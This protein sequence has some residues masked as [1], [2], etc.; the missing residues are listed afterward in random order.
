M[1][2]YVC[3]HV[4]VLYAVLYLFF[5]LFKHQWLNDWFEIRFWWVCP[6][7][8]VQLSLHSGHTIDC[9]Q[10]FVKDAQHP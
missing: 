2:V 5:G 1:C 7:S 3:V 8:G 4:C 9:L 10:H 6:L